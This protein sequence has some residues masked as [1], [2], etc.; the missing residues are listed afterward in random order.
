MTATEFI[1]LLNKTYGLDPWPTVFVVDAETYANCCQYIF[2]WVNEDSRRVVH[3]G[4]HA[5]GLMFKN[6]ELIYG[7]KS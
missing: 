2:N 7:A 3:L 6:I 5:N 4:H 1:Y